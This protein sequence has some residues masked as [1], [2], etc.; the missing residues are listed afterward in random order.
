MQYLVGLCITA[1]L[2]GFA[3]GALVMVIMRHA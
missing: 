3:A 1:A 2:I